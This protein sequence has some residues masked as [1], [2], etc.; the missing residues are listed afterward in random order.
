MVTLWAKSIMNHYTINKYFHCVTPLIYN[1]SKLNTFCIQFVFV[2]LC[3]HRNIRG[4]LKICSKS[5]I[6]E[7]DEMMEAILKV[8]S[9][10][11]HLNINFKS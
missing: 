5:V 8:S 10:F 1:S 7:P 4:S 9:S 11:L 6:F 2:S 3:G